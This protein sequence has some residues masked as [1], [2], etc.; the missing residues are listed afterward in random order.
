MGACD[1][2]SAKNQKINIRKNKGRQPFSAPI[3]RTKN[4]N[5]LTSSLSTTINAFSQLDLKKFNSGNKNRPSLLYKYK[6]TYC[7]KGEQISIM[8]ATLQ[9]LQGN[10]L[11]NNKTENN[12]TKAANSIY[13]IVDEND[14]SNGFE[15]ISEGIVDEDMVQ[16]STDKSTIDSYIEFIGQKD[17]FNS[18]KN[19]ID[20]YHNNKNS[21]NNNKLVEHCI[22]KESQWRCSNY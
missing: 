1:S 6:G 18:P 11:L 17:K 16:K 7:K 10:S 20:I 19:K 21:K 22:S 4:D 2:I 14:S 13:T 3:S 9:D 15:I 5:N 8:T 12:N